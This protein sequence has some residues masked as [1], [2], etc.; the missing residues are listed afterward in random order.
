MS[1]TLSEV[2]AK[3]DAQPDS[4]LVGY[5]F[6]D[7]IHYVVLNKQGDDIDLDMVKRLNEVYD[8]VDKSQ[9]K[10]ILVTIGRKDTKIFNQ[11]FNLEFWSQNAL[12]PYSSLAEYQLL[13]GK[14]LTLGLPSLCV[15]NGHTF[16]GGLFLGVTHDFRIMT[17]D[18]SKKVCLS[19]INLGF[20]MP[21]AYG[22]IIKE[23]TTRQAYRKLSLGAM[24]SPQEALDLD[25]VD[26]L[27]DGI[28]DCES[29]IKAFAE[30]YDS[31]CAKRDPIKTN[32]ETTFYELTKQI[33]KGAFTA[34]EVAF[35]TSS[36][37]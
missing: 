16:A 33:Q 18:S 19:E 5:V 6:D 35:F 34:D 22:R 27:F 2:Y 28:D 15:M 13:L 1:L 29:K 8:L 23:T 4:K 11:G 12:N 10:G 36:K 24:L 14:I 37:L 3:V 9:D 31:V 21:K 30:K 25:V 20:N 7:P 17:N 32:K 26:D